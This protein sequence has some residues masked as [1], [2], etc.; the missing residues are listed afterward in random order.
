VNT[1]AIKIP[2]NA[3]NSKLPPQSK[4]T[5]KKTHELQSAIKKLMI[6]KIATFKILKLTISILTL[7]L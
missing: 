2:K 1:S 3:G 7:S 5:N 4:K 6:Q